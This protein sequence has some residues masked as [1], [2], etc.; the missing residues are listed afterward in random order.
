MGDVEVLY[1]IIKE[2]RP[3]VW[4]SIGKKGTSSSNKK[5]DSLNQEF[6]VEVISDKLKDEVITLFPMKQSISIKVA[7]HVEKHGGKALLNLMFTQYYEWMGAFALIFMF[8][9]N[10]EKGKSMKSL[11]YIFYPKNRTDR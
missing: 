5:L 7:G 2:F 3:D 6:E 9:Y 8:L 4:I 1:K 10:G 11:F